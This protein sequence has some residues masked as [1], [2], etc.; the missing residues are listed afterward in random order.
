MC[1]CVECFQSRARKNFLP[2][3]SPNKLYTHTFSMAHILICFEFPLIPAGGLSEAS[4]TICVAQKYSTVQLGIANTQL[5]RPD[6][7]S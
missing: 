4:P 3:A 2:A 1:V 5:Q 7:R 6:W